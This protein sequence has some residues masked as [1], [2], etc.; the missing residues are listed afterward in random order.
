MPEAHRADV[1]AVGRDPFEFKTPIERI[2]GGL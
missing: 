2:E 1:V